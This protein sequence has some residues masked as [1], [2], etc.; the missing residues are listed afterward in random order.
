MKKKTGL[1]LLLVVSL[2]ITGCSL[3]NANETKE[4][5]KK[6][7]S[8]EQVIKE[9]GYSITF[10][11]DFEK[12]EID[13]FD[14][15]YQNEKIGFTS[16]RE[17]FETLAAINI[18]KDSTLAEYG[19]KIIEANKILNTFKPSKDESYMYTT[20]EKFITNQTFYYYTVVKKGTDSFWLFNF[21]CRKSDKDQ[22]LANI[23]KYAATLKVD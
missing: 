14:T 16:L 12:K 5:E 11:K 21:F 7:V 6:E 3:F 2:L 1:I 9:E 13:G 15:F 4:E 19:E 23:E 10:S 20:Y 22:E 8:N 18:N 17:R